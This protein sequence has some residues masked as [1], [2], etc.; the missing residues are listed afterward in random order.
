MSSEPTPL[1]VP[2]FTALK[3]QGRKISMLTAYDYTMARLLDEAGVDALLIGDS[4][5]MV[6]QGHDT[7][8]PVT[9]DEMIYHARLVGRAV[10]RALT[11]VDLP[12]PTYHL[13]ETAAVEAAAR[14][15][16]ET[17]CQAVKLEGGS[18]Q[19]EVIAALVRAG[20]PVMA[21]CGLRPQNVR[22][23][24]GYRVQRQQ[25]ALLADAKAAEQAGAFGVVLEC[26]PADVARRI[27][28]E[29]NI[30]TIGIGAGNGCDGQVLVVNDLLGLTVGFTPRFVKAYA[31]LGNTIQDAVR[32]YCEEVR[33][34]QFPGDEHTFK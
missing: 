13:G 32:R 12:F 21:H 4:L 17:N 3:S 23:L 24:G 34:G 33:S 16:K 18:D 27:T 1:T 30:P 5:A 11:I 8:L 19:A 14:V 10:R 28:A 2:R 9:L 29:L 20:I 6:V 26:I 7:T 31:D 22:V 15:L 25:E